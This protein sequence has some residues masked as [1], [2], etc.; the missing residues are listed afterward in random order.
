MKELFEKKAVELSE[1][2][3]RG[4]VSSEEITKMFLSRIFEVDEKVKAFITVCEEEAIK[5]AKELD[6][7]RG[8]GDYSKL[9]GVPVAIKDNITTR[10][11][12]TTCASNILRNYFPPYDA[13]VVQKLKKAG[14][15]I[16]GKT[17]MDEFAMGS[18]TENSAFFPTRN[19]W[20]LGR[21]PGGSSGGSAA[22]VSSCEVPLALGSDTG[23]S[24]RQPASFCSVVGLNPTYGRVSRFGLVAFASSLDRIGPIT[25]YVEDCATLFEIIAG[26]D[27][28]DSTCP[29]IPSQRY[30]DRG[31]LK[32]LKFGI[33][34]EYFWGQEAGE[35]IDEDVRK[36][37]FEVARVMEKEFG[38]IPV[39]ISLPHT[40]YA[41]AVYYIIAPAEASSNLARYDGVKYGLRIPSDDLSD[42]YIRTRTKGFGKE[43]KRRIL[44]G[45]Y[46]LSAGYWEAYYG[47]AQRVRTLIKGD[48]EEVFKKVDV[49]LAPVSPTPSFK[50]GEKVDDPLKMYLSDVFTIPASLAGIPGISVPCGFARG[51]PV[52]VQILGKHFDE[53]TIIDVAWAIEETLDIAGK[54]PSLT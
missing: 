30:T 13:T 31:K 35:G 19:P 27:P 2:I 33:P 29:D 32:D 41:I 38:M 40:K 54:L 47:R 18:S 36:V 7:K 42:M 28:K 10:G 22:A 20:D 6:R 23:G 9:F 48:F 8:T 14:L 12:R 21:V 49:I 50:L 52:G 16:V 26:Y 25:G 11:I 53:K 5:T 34:K 37:C 44:I 51:L 39:D 17:N 45:T 1:A 4:E 46:V 24:I 3:K 15:V 43:V